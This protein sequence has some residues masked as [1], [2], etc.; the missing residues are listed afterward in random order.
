M[1]CDFPLKALF[2]KENFNL[3]QASRHVDDVVRQTQ[4][5]LGRA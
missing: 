4:S 1:D 5:W 2:F 3:M